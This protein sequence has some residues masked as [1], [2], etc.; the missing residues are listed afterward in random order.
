MF[1]QK[2]RQLALDVKRLPSIYRSS[3]CKME[4]YEVIVNNNN[5]AV[6]LFYRKDLSSTRYTKRYVYD[7]MSTINSWEILKKAI[8]VVLND[9]LESEE[10]HRHNYKSNPC[11]QNAL[12]S[13][14]I[15]EPAH[16]EGFTNGNIMRYTQVHPYDD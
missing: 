4:S 6:I 3:A 11:I 8:K 14:F 5:E 15:Y 2:V 10:I 9:N 13:Y 16:V 7:V 1:E 12:K